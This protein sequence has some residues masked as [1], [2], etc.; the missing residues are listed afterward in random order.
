MAFRDFP[1]THRFSVRKRLGAGAAGIIYEVWDNQ[2]ECR[3]ALKTLHRVDPLSLLFLKNEFRSL[4]D[5]S[6]PNLVTLHE[7]ISENDQWFFTMELVDGVD[8]LEWV[9]PAATAHRRNALSM[10]ATEHSNAAP[11]ELAT[12]RSCKEIRV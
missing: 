6:H 2:R 12:R 3:L 4:A 5:L 1:G 10:A 11:R 8:F 7:L 9:N